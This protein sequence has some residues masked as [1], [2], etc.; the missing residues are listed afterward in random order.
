MKNNVIKKEHKTEK[1]K[2]RRAIFVYEAAR[3]E[4]KI[5]KR[6]IV[7]EHWDSRDEAFKNQF[8]K[9]IGRQCGND[10]F[11]SAEDAHNS[12][13]REHIK[14]GWVYGEKR[15]PLKRVHP[16]M[17]PFKELPKDERDKDE[18]F[19]RLCAVAEAIHPC[20]GS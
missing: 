15:D 6:R 10:K 16:D 17:V 18:I 19:I 2:L 5:S 8:I 14:M 20:Y 9:V 13:W 11:K 3:I 1:R 7:P 4:A 12:W